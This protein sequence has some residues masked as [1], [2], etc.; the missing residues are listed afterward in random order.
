MKSSSTK[1]PLVQVVETAET[2]LEKREKILKD[3]EKF[4]ELLH[5]EEMNPLKVS[6][7]KESLDPLDAFMTDVSSKLGKNHHW[8]RC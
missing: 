7:D 6:Q 4:S 3:I 2:L 1:S 8:K 5:F